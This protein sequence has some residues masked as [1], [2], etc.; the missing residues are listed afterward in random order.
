M[1][2]PSLISNQFLKLYIDVLETVD[3]KSNGKFPEFVNARDE[4]MN[5]KSKYKTISPNSDLRTAIKSAL[6]DDYIVV[7]LGKRK[8]VFMDSNNNFHH[9]IGITQELC[10]VLSQW[11]IIQTVT[12]DYCGYH[13]CDG[14]VKRSNIYIGP[15]MAKKITSD[16]K[17]TKK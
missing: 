13:I 5:N 14:L 16:Y 4:L 17:I 12:M 15:S 10:D 11:E 2:L 7:K 1:I 3:A 6:L 9:V 8:C